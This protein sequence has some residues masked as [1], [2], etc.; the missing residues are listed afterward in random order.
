MHARVTVYAC[1]CDYDMH[2]CVTVCSCMCA[3]RLRSV[4]SCVG[5]AVVMLWV[6]LFH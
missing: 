6:E 3:G 1:M 2:A 4:T 5:V